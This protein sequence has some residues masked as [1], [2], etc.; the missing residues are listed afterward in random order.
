VE[1]IIERSAD[2]LRT[3]LRDGVLKAMSQHNSDK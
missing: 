3:I 2:A 1:E